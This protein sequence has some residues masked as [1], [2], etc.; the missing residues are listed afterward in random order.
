M[1]VISFGDG[2]LKTFCSGRWKNIGH[3][4]RELC[5]AALEGKYRVCAEGD[6]KV[7][8]V[9][10]RDMILYC[11]DVANRQWMPG[12]PIETAYRVWS[13]SMT[14]CKGKLYIS[15]GICE[16]TSKP[17]KTMVSLIAGRGE[18][19]CRVQTQQEPNMVFKRYNHSMGCMG[20]QVMVCGGEIKDPRS[21]CEMFDPSSRRWSQLKYFPHG[22]L[23]VSLLPMWNGFKGVLVLG[24]I[25]VKPNAADVSVELST[26]MSM[27]NGHTR[28]WVA[29][30]SMPIPLCDIQAVYRGRSLWLL[31]A[32]KQVIV[33]LESSTKQ[34]LCH[35]SCVLEYRIRKASWIIHKNIPALGED[36]FTFTL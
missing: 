27:Y 23:N 28:Q 26:S 32:V 11:L 6:G 5:S 15:G 8:V 13:A 25:S 19:T 7:F 1:G 22:N 33:D 29:L 10:T 20:E 34:D 18:T 14:Y 35:V 4:P 24:G 36:V 16:N 17:L 21:T 2:A 9:N 31:A 3:V 12:I 30:G